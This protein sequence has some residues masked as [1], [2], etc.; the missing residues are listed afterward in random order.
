MDNLNL[1][2]C[3]G[4]NYELGNDN[5]LIWKFKNDMNFFKNMTINNSVIMGRRTYESIGRILPKRE[6]II[7][8]RDKNFNID[9]ALIFN[10][11]N[12]VINYIK[13]NYDKIFY[14]IGGASIYKYYLDYCSSLYLTEVNDSSNA[15]VYFPRFDKNNYD[16]SI[17]YSYN[18]NGIDY[19]IKKYVRK[20]VK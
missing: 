3:I 15:T 8:T 20:R 17:L 6:N 5:D 19:D 1:I 18:E 13:D 9:N 16:S 2:A 7:I 4:K 11:N 14:V 12:S 10:D